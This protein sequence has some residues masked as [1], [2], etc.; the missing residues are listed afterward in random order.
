MGHLRDVHAHECDVEHVARSERIPRIK[1]AILPPA[2]RDSES[3]HLFDAGE[4]AALGVGVVPPLKRD[5]DQRVRDYCHLTFGNQWQQ[6][7]DIIIIHRVH[8][9]QMAAGGTHAEAVAG[10]FRRHCFDMTAHRVIGFVAV[11]IEHQ[12]TVGGDT[13]DVF[14]GF[15]PLLHCPLEMRDAADNIDAAIQRTNEVFPPILRAVKPVLR[16]SDQL[17]F[18]IGG[19]AAFY[20]EHRVNAAQMVGRCVDMGPDR[21]KSHGGCPVTIAHSALD[22]FVDGCD[23]AQLA[24]QADALDQRAA[25]I[26]ARQTIGQ[27]CVHME[28]RIDKGRA[29]QVT[30]CIN[31]PDSRGI[32]LPH[33]G[34]PV[35]R[36]CNIGD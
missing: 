11:D 24:P 1:N 12:P 21:Q 6:L 19:D 31:G 22:H 15:C 8:R 10:D 23:F 16:K 36:D 5:V 27:G 28:M 2:H 13:G 33:S 17:Q 4:T 29:D 3:L 35:A 18:E 34:N 32:K 9:G 20:F 14:D 7:G 26:H 25:G 30:A